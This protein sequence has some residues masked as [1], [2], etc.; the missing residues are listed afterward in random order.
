MS[1]ERDIQT[2]I[3]SLKRFAM[4][5]CHAAPTAD[6]LVQEALLKAWAH[7]DQF[8]EGTNFNAWMFTILHNVF[9]SQKRRMRREVEDVDGGYALRL[10]TQASQEWHVR[11]ADVARGLAQLPYG[12][13]EALFLVGVEGMSYEDAAAIM[14]CEVGTVRSRINR[15]REKLAAV[16]GEDLPKTELEIAWEKIQADLDRRDEDTPTLFGESDL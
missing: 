9:L 2:V 14:G 3:P 5:L 15:A 7:Q 11:L 13:Q 4:S 10:S 16:L 12:Q 6:D 1:F 8:Q